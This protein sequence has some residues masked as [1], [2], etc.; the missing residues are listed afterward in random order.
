MGVDVGALTPVEIGV[1]I[2]AR[3][4]AVRRA[5][6]ASVKRALSVVAPALPCRSGRQG[7]GRRNALRAAGHRRGLSEG[8]TRPRR[9]LPLRA[10]QR[11]ATAP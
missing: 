7:D 11:G 4:V 3:L 9:A 6:R 10:A 2:V 5:E 1:S 8:S